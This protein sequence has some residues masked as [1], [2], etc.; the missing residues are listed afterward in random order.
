[1]ASPDIKQDSISKITD[2]KRAG[3]VAEVVEHW[4]SKYQALSSPATVLPKIK[5]QVYLELGSMDTDL[6]RK[7]LI[8]SSLLFH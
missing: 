6:E 2:A 1:L 3:R 5:K 8:S 7:C 4:L